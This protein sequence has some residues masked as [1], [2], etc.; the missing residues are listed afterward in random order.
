M[1]EEIVKNAGSMAVGDTVDHHARGFP[2]YELQS[3]AENRDIEVSSPRLR[4]PPFPALRVCIGNGS[5]G[6]DG[7]RS[8]E[9]NLF[10]GSGSGSRSR[11]GGGN[12]ES[13]SSGAVNFSSLSYLY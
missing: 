4:F 9:P 10:R 1:Q 2:R 8:L 12:S 5:C 6:Y 13:S 11:L 7:T 3:A